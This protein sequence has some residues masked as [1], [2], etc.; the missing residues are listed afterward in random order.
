MGISEQ[1]KERF[2]NL[3][4]RL[5]NLGADTTY[6]ISDMILLLSV[7]L[8][9]L[10]FVFIAALFLYGLYHYT[11]IFGLLLLGGG[12]GLSLLYIS[13]KLQEVAMKKSK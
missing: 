4:E 10:L 1:L 6:Y 2:H 12:T 9:F 8:F 3:L 5:D 7:V 11:G 13:K